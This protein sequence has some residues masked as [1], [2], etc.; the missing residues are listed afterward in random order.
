M[1]NEF[2]ARSASDKTE[3]WPIWFVARKDAPSR[4]VLDK[5]CEVAGIPRRAGAVLADKQTA[6]WIAEE[7]NKAEGQQ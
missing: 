7:A 6:I 1:S 2:F 4:N 5:A 3:N